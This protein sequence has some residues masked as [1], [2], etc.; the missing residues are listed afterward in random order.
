MFEDIFILGTEAA[1]SDDSGSQDPSQPC[2]A[3]PHW[4][5]VQPPLGIFL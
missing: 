3:S 4:K 2:Y 1:A 5:E